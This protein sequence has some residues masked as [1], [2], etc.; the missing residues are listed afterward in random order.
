MTDPN[1]PGPDS[2]QPDAPLPVPPASE[3][4]AATPAFPA[5][6]EF[7][8]AAE[9]PPAAAPVAS[10][11]PATPGTPG[12]PAAQNAEQPPV[13]AAAPPAPPAGP[14]GPGAPYQAGPGAPQQAPTNTL[15]IVALIASFFVSVAGIICGHIALSQIKRTG[16]RG[17]GLALAGTI[18]GYVSFAITVISIIALVV[19]G[20][21]AAAVGSS[22]VSQLDDATTQ[23]EELEAE[24]PDSSELAPGASESAG[25]PRSAEFCAA[26]TKATEITEASTQPDFEASELDAYRALAAIE[27]PNQQVYADFLAFAE[28]P[29]PDAA[30]SDFSAAMEAFSTAMYDDYLACA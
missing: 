19:I 9:V 23:L 5:A 12:T 17:R 29:M 2:T 20:G 4:P 15:A 24:L 3:Q 18:I 8:A 27:S 30:S 28:Q 21:L 25:D 22:T 6:P 7:P 26:F 14:Q 13:Y 1:T 10:E 16:E 11:F